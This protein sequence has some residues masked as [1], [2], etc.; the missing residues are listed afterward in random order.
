MGSVFCAI[1]LSVPFYFIW[2]ALAPIYLASAPEIYQ[3]LPFWHVMGI[4]VLL[5]IVRLVLFP[6]R[7]QVNK[8]IWKRRSL[9]RSRPARGLGAPG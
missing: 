5:P 2:S 7:V 3:R 4:L 9:A 1:F 6:S 8:Y